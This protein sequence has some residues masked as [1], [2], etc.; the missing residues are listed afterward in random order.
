MKIWTLTVN[1][2][3]ALD[4]YTC[5]CNEDPSKLINSEEYKDVYQDVCNEL[6]DSFS[7]LIDWREYS[8]DHDEDEM[9]ED[10]ILEL[11]DEVWQMAYNDF[12]NNLTFDA[13]EVDSPEDFEVLIDERENGNISD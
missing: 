13:Y 5:Y 4:T 7:H 6:F 9:S 2:V 10:E 8:D 1:Y 3:Q 11:D 12:C